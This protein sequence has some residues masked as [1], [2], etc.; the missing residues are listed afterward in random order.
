M[1]K[2]L[3]KNKK[4][5]R[6]SLN[7]VLLVFL[8]LII[9]FLIFN[10]YNSFRILEKKEILASFFI[11]EHIGFD[12]NNSALTFGLVQLGHSSSR[13]VFV[14]NNYDIP[15]LVTI[16]S[17]GD[18]SDF[19]IVSDNDFILKPNEKKQISFSVFPSKDT[20]VKEYKGVV[21]IILKKI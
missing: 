7:Y 4:I 21:E 11:S 16:K 13:E 20:E 10:L 8:I 9:M 19:L 17:N 15:V 2:N 12:L 3:E 6:V 18:I 14:E 1:E 5:N